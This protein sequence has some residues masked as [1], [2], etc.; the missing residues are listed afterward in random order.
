[1][2][3]SCLSSAKGANSLLIM[4]RT[5]TSYTSG[6]LQL[7][8]FL[9]LTGI[10]QGAVLE[11]LTL[12]HILYQD[13]IILDINSKSGN[14]PLPYSSKSTLQSQKLSICFPKIL[15]DLVDISYISC[16]GHQHSSLNFLP[17]KP[18][19]LKDASWLIGL[20]NLLKNIYR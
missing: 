3:F 9:F 2:Q 1:M 12:L 19:L 14:H 13:C 10:L 5:P 6:L 4:S 8:L 11:G 17:K 7:L 16:V 15:S 18:V 20:M